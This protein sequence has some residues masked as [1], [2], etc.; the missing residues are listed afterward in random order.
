MWNRLWTTAADCGCLWM[1][2]GGFTVCGST[3]DANRSNGESRRVL[4]NTVTGMRS[5]AG[6]SLGVE[7]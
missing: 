2:S 3:T 7:P 6:N 1:S 4:A 5:A